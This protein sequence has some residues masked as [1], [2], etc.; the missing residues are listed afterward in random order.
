LT[1]WIGKAWY[2]RKTI[3]SIYTGGSIS[4]VGCHHITTNLRCKLQRKYRMYIGHLA[5]SQPDHPAIITAKTG[6]VLTYAQLDQKSNQVAH[7]LRAK[8]VEI[9]DQVSILAE[10]NA[11]YMILIWGALRAGALVTPINGHLS[12]P[13]IKHVL[14]HSETKLLFV[15]DRF[16]AN[17]PAGVNIETPSA[18]LGFPTTPIAD[19]APGALHCY[20]SGTTGKPKGVK[21]S[22][23]T[24]DIVENGVSQNAAYARAYGL[25]SETV[26]MTP[27]PLFYS[28][29]S[30]FSVAVHETGGCVVMTDRFSPVRA[31]QYIEKY[32][33]THSQWVPTM[34][35][36]MLNLAPELR[37]CDVSS[38]KLAIHGGAACP[39][40]VKRKMI[41]WFGPIVTEIY[42]CTEL[43]GLCVINSETWLTKPGSVG[44]AVV[45]TIHICDEGGNELPPGTNGLI[46]FEGGTREPFEYTKNPEKTAAARHPAHKEWS[47]IGDMGRLDTDGFLYL[48]GRR[49]F[50]IISGGVNIFP[51]A[52]EDAIRTHPAVIDVAVFGS[53]HESLGEIVKAV[54]VSRVK[55]TLALKHE[56]KL[57]VRDTVARYAVP[58]LEFADE[59]PYV[60]GKLSKRR[61]QELY[62]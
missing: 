27:A 51:S 28:A 38:L 40:E 1:M 45:G 55:P 41:D 60:N 24:W 56:L 46:Y 34:F 58:K 2:P 44:K 12:P 52:V 18:S 16:A 57:L 13:E 6:E 36:R 15:S 10:N 5:K 30:Y 25:N 23:P 7:L 50:M 20:S 35:V 33:V 49:D 3:N 26:Y 39:I 22:R 53:P 54:V 61:L 21:I 42:A 31:L 59:L 37:K 48:V 17:V 32:R 11:E 4:T 62:P 43:Y 9:G 8:G 29:A 47:T 14:E 19:E